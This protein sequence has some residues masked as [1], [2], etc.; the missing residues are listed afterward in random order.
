LTIKNNRR[1][2]SINESE[3]KVIFLQ[4]QLFFLKR[5][6]AIAILRIQKINQNDI[7]AF[8]VIASKKL[9]ISVVI[10]TTKAKTMPEITNAS[11]KLNSNFGFF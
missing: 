4:L 11:L 7:I 8:A 2:L 9:K 3:G 10:D 5:N 1:I 6:R